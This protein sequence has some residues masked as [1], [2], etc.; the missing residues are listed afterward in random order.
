[1]WNDSVVAF[2]AP[3]LSNAGPAVFYG[4]DGEPNGPYS[5]TSETW[6]NPDSFQI[7]SAG[8]DGKYG[9]ATDAH[10]HGSVRS[11]IRPART[12]DVAGADDDNVTNFCPKSRLGDAKP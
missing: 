5:S 4:F 9:R 1:M 11:S 7:I 10:A 12:Y 2:T 3:G 8:L 6:A